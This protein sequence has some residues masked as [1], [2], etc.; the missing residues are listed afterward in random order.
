LQVIRNDY[1]AQGFE[2]I[3]IGGYNGD[4]WSSMKPYN[5]LYSWQFLMDGP[6]YPTYSAYY[7]NGYIPLNYVIDRQG[8]VRYWAEG[9]SETAVRNAIQTWLVGVE[10]GGNETPAPKGI[11]LAQNRPNPSRGNTEISFT[12]PR[13]DAVRLAL[14]DAQGRLVRT[15]TEGSQSAGT[16]RLALSGLEAGVYFYRLEA[17][18]TSLTRRMVVAK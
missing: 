18:N 17:G 1:S 11:D 13:A 2:I 3:G 5:R 7:Q 15:L 9:F 10:A 8:I 6:S 12:L 16:H 14:Y 4:S